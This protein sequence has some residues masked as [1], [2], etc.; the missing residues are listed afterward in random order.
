VAAATR[1]VTV[2]TRNITRRGSSFGDAA[3]GLTDIRAVVVK[4]RDGDTLTV[5]IPDWHPAWPPSA[6]GLAGID[7][8]ELGDA[9]PR[10]RPLAS[11]PGMDPV[12]V[13]GGK[14]GHPA[15]RVPGSLSRL[16]ARVVT[17]DGVDLGQEL[18]PRGLA[19]PWNGRGTRRGDAAVAPGLGR[20][21]LRQVHPVF[22]GRGI[23]AGDVLAVL[24]VGCV[25]L[26]EIRGRER[27]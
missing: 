20:I 26:A 16:S 2:A 15:R 18:V 9:R 19:K 11:W 27:E 23:P 1:A 4:V 21:R 12:P 14:R 17:E 22:R 5:T 24:G 7:T 13:P 6:C 8:P 25:I 10:S 3:P